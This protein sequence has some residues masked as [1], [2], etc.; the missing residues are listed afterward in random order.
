VIITGV[1]LVYLVRLA[2][3]GWRDVSGIA[4]FALFGSWAVALPV[5]LVLR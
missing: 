2:A 4:G 3:P 1:C 5:L